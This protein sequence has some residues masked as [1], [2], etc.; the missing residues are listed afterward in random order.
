M[1]QHFMCR[2]TLTVLMMVE[3]PLMF[4]NKPTLHNERV[5]IEGYELL[6]TKG[7]L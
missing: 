3:L 2:V 5:D 7:L 6:A 1:Y 4:S